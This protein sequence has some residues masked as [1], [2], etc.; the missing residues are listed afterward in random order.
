[1]SEVLFLA[2]RVPFPPDRGDKIRSNH[3]LRRIAELA[4]V[5]VGAL[6]DDAADLAQEGELAAI[7]ASRCI[8][9]RSA[10]LP[11]AALA[12]LGQ[13]LP[14]SLAAFSSAKLQRWVN[15]VLQTRPIS[16]IFVFSGQMAQYVP[17]EFR[18][19]VV[20]DFVDVDS[21]K[22]EAYA[23]TG[24]LPRRLLYAREARLLR[25]FEEATA[26]RATTS[27]F[28]SSE[29]RAL[30][31]SRLSG[32]ARPDVRALGNGIDTQLFDPAT[33]EPAPELAGDGPSIVFTGQMDYPPNIT[34]VELFAHEVMPLIRQ[35]HPQARFA[36]VGRAPTP[37]VRA[38]GGLNGTLVTGAVPD[39]R[40]WL[41]GADIVTAPL[42]IA[43]GVQNKVLEAMAMARPVLLTPAAATGI[44]GTDSEHFALAEAPLALAGRALALLADPAAAQS[45]GTAARRFVVDE[46]GWDR[47]LEPLCALIGAQSDAA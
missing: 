26:R 32:A 33:V 11:L 17:P 9:R 34:A 43:R 30:F 35:A 41:A 40:P 39:V 4:P 7:A 46:C 31:E 15:Q 18:G 2:H 28:V 8:V 21:A 6:A 23:Q 14:V 22:F 16:A 38:L 29:E 20:M 13:G 25:R 36:I 3:L 27:L 1:M 37:A 42:L 10:P 24:A 12:A 47:V 45:M 44:G 5:H 19:R